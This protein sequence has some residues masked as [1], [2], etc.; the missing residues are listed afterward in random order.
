MTT[1]ESISVAAAADGILR[2]GDAPS[3]PGTDVDASTSVPNQTATEGGSAFN[4]DTSSYITGDDKG[5]GTVTVDEL[6]GTLA[7]I[8]LAFSSE[9]ITGTQTEGVCTFRLRWTNDT[10][11]DDKRSTNR[12]SIVIG[13]EL[14]ATDETAPTKVINVSATSTGSVATIIHD[15][16]SDPHDG[17]NAGSGMQEYEYLDADDEVLATLAASSGLSPS[18]TSADIGTLSPAGSSNESG[19]GGTDTAAGQIGENPSTAD[20]YRAGRLYPFAGDFV[21][22]VK[23]ESF[24]STSGFPKAGIMARFGSEEDD[25][26]FMLQVYGNKNVRIEYRA[27]KGGLRVT[28]GT[29]AVTAL[30]VY[31]RLSLSGTTFTGSYSQDGVTFSPCGSFNMALPGSFT[32]SRATCSTNGSTPVSVVYTEDSFWTGSQVS[33]ELTTSSAGPFYVRGVDNEGNTGSKSGPVFATIAPPG[34]GVF[35]GTTLK[36]YPGFVIAG[37]E[38]ESA[39]SIEARWQKLFTASPDRK[40][41]Y[42]P[43]GI[44][45]GVAVRLNWNRFYVNQSVRPENPK[46]H[47]DPAYDWSKLD[48]VFA[49]NAVQNEGALVYIEV[50]DISYFST[51]KAP[52]WLATAPHNGIFLSGVDDGSGSQKAIPKYY[53]YANPDVR[54][55]STDTNYPI[56]EEFAYFHEAMHDHLV[57]TANIDKVMGVSGGG[58]VYLGSGFTPP[59]DWNQNNFYHGTA[60]RHTL[61]AKVWA[62]SQI[63]VHAGSLTTGSYK[64]IAWDYMQDPLRGMSFPDMKL[65]GT[66][67]IGSISRFY[68]DT[69]MI[70]QK[71]NRP[72]R[73]GTEGNGQRATT[74]FAPG[75]PNPWGYSGV[76][77]PQTPSHILWVLSGEPKGANKDSRLGQAGDDPAGLMPVHQIVID[78][79]RSWQ[80]YSPDVSEWH[81]AIDTFG[82]PGTFAFPYLPIGYVP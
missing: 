46:D 24:S 69:G 60:L 36:F 22:S 59:S 14:S 50:E 25:P 70:Y 31:L 13:A 74:N 2:Y 58:E 54:G 57:A 81:T 39:S 10:D 27:I 7:A 1:V 29:G 21:R 37:T 15:P 34:G 33:K 48:A 52:A 71:D 75:I 41:S 53:R 16:A 28:A 63:F 79:N 44:Y 68:D 61:L 5:D 30:P 77:V 67:N 82:P 80:K 78:F 9:A 66:N 56:V 51:P 4:W 3:A 47:N 11:P 38:N 40:T 76:T 73:Q 6:T 65:N 19:A 49:I 45:G 17:T 26:F 64:D 20:A 42:R 8:G 62:E 55:I 35:P 43:K 18:F 32:L 12:I 23:V 72:L